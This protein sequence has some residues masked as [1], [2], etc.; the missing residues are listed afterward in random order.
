MMEVMNSSEIYH[1]RIK[2]N[3][4]QVHDG[5]YLRSAKTFRLRP[6][7]CLRLAPRI[8]LRPQHTPN[9]EITL[10]YCETLESAANRAKA[11]VPY[12]IHSCICT[13]TGL[14]CFDPACS[15]IGDAR[16]AK[17]ANDIIV[18]TPP[19]QNPPPGTPKDAWIQP[20]LDVEKV[21]LVFEWVEISA[22]NEAGDRTTTTGARARLV[23]SANQIEYSKGRVDTLSDWLNLANILSSTE[24]A[25]IEG[26]GVIL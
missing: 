4:V 3:G 14:S 7:H 12:G 20:A 1:P 16:R 9:S 24:S 2:T 26:S 10:S 25:S 18:L 23:S 21:L 6:K 19:F 8:L 11:L 22:Y 13:D 17:F 5:P 15:K